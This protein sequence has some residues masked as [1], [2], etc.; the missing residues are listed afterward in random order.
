MGFLDFLF[1]GNK[2]KDYIEP[3]TDDTAVKQDYEFDDD[4]RMTREE[5]KAYFADIFATEFPE[6]EV[7]ADV[8]ANELADLTN[9]IT[10]VHPACTPVDFL[11]M[12]NDKPFIALV[13]VS[14]STYRGMN[15]LGTKAICD[16]AQLQYVRFYTDMPNK[17]DY[18]V[19]RLRSFLY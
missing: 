9:V 2:K 7:R 6:F 12:A 19:N 11:V 16:L 13:L 8:P 1:G 4:T 17:R 18:V 3:A 14:A 5:L 15:V 10:V